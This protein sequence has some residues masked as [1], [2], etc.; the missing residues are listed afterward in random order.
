M[1]ILSF[2]NLKLLNLIQ[3]KKKI[4]NMLKGKLKED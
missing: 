4:M 3:E 2:L 1:D